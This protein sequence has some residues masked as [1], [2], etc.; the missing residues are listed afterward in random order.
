MGILDGIAGNESVQRFLET[1]FGTKLEE[2]TN[3]TG[4]LQKAIE[5][6]KDEIETRKKSEAKLLTAIE[7]LTDAIRERTTKTPKS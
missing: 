1:K 5:A 4:K 6:L 7:E 2:A 3:A